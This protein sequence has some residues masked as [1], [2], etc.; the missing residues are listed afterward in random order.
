MPRVLAK[1]LHPFFAHPDWPDHP[2]DARGLSLAG[3]WVQPGAVVSVDDSPEAW[4]D[5][6]GAYLEPLQSA[7]PDEEPQQLELEP[8]PELEPEIDQKPKRKR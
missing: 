1:A 6:Y 5:C 8:E 3:G 2:Q 4:R 7:K